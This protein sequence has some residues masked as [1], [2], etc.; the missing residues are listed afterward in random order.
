M[1]SDFSVA[2]VWVYAEHI[3]LL[4]PLRDGAVFDM[5]QQTYA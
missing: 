3:K 5:P 2:E 1:K 4:R